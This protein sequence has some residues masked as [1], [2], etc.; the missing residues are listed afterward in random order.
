[1]TISTTAERTTVRPFGWRDK[2]GYAF[3]D[4]ANDMT[5]MIQ[6]FFL[7]VYFTKVIGI[8]PLHVGGLIA[9]VRVLDAFTDVGMGILVDR[10]KPARD[11]KF[12]PWIRRIAVP[13]ALAAALLFQPFIANWAYGARLAW[14][15]VFYILWGSVFYTA[16]NIPTARWP[17]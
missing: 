16:I 17:R 12:K 2:I 3:G 4:L 9:A 6:A 11:G 14:M 1:M 8:D 10:L 7:M 13:V 5:F 15:V